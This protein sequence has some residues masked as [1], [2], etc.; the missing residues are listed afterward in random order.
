MRRCAA[1][2]HACTFSKR[3]RGR[4]LALPQEVESLAQEVESLG[5]VR[6]L[7]SDSV[8]VERLER[9]KGPSLWAGGHD[10]DVAHTDLK[11]TFTRLD[12]IDRDSCLLR[13]ARQRHLDRASDFRCP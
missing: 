6:R 8:N 13:P 10:D 1:G 5:R 7:T 4:C 12:L 2:R 9:G 3:D 11:D